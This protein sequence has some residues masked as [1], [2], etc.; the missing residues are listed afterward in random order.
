[1]SIGLKNLCRTNTCGDLTKKEVGKEVTLMGW[2]QSRRDHGGLIFIDLR[3]RYGITQIVFH[4]QPDQSLHEK[5]HCL[6]NEYVVAVQG[7]VKERPSGMA[8]PNLSTGEIEVLAKRLEILNESLTPPFLIEEES[9]AL[10]ELRL[11][12]RYLDLRRPPMRNN[13]VLRHRVTQVVRNFLNQHR[14]IEIETPLLTRSMPEG[15]RDYLV[16]SRIHP[17]KFYALAQSPQFY[18]QLLMIAGFDRYYQIARCLRDEDQRADRQPEH[19]QIDL[20]LSFVLK[21]EIFELVEKMFQHIFK[22]MLNVDLELPFP[23]LSFRVAMDKYGTDKP[24]LRFGLELTDLSDI[25]IQ[26]D[27]NIFRSVLEKKGEVK[28][29]NVKSCAQWSRKEL[30][31][32]EI[33]VQRLGAKGLLWLKRTEGKISSPLTKFL[34]ESLFNSL[35]KRTDLKEGDLLLILADQPKVVALALG[36]LRNQLAKKMG[37]VQPNMFKFCWITDFPMFKWNEEENRFE[38]E[39][40]IFTMH[41]EEDWEFLEKD[42]SRVRGELY[43]L[44]CNGWEMASGS[45]RIHRRDI[46]E[47]VMQVIGMSKEEAEKRFGFLLEAFQYGAPPHGGIAVGL[48][49]LVMLMAGRENI[50]DVIPFPKTLTATAL[51]EQAPSEVNEQQLKELHIRRE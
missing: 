26:S 14:F 37:L 17:G 43:D 18:K 25:A 23:Q 45:I 47:R 40:H 50:R 30:D 4:P 20:E 48:D 31:E 34:N 35:F 11:K 38:P 42:P 1:M 24:D 16:P 5:A 19:T 2:V 41:K 3:D 51:L 13:I 28:G 10:E 6:K 46:Q 29:I 7:M 21:E 8:N 12:Y 9:G 22:E 27:Y 33:F 39:H 49:R 32:L 44:V 36:A 15:A